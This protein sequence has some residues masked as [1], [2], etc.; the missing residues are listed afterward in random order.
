MTEETTKSARDVLTLDEIAA[1]TGFSRRTASR[2][3]E[4]EPGVNKLERPATLG[5]RRY[6]SIWIPRAVY[7]RVLRRLLQK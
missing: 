3:F 5:K 6:R 1:L 7:E 4:N 2:L